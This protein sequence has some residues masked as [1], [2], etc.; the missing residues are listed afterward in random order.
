MAEAA[1]NA[2]AIQIIQKV[3]SVM[4]SLQVIFLV[5]PRSV[6]P[7]RQD[8]KSNGAAQEGHRS[9]GKGLLQTFKEGLTAAAGDDRLV[10][11]NMCRSVKGLAWTYTHGRVQYCMFSLQ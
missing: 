8:A 1:L 6:T 7:V 11:Q 5:P 9:E 3:V 2:E 10:R 4:L